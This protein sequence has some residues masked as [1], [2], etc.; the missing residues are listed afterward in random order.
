MRLNPKPGAGRGCGR[1]LMGA[2]DDFSWRHRC[3]K[4]MLL[5]SAFRRPSV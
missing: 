1:F 5:S 2:I 4:K 3:T